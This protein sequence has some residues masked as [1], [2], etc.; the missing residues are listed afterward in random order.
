MLLWRAFDPDLIEV[1]WQ[2]SLN[3][4]I[5]DQ[6]LIILPEHQAVFPPFH[7]QVLLHLGS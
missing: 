1:K 4:L 6:V 2:N 3:P 5:Q 7:L